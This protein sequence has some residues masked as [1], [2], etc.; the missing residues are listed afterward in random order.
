MINNSITSINIKLLLLLCMKCNNSNKLIIDAYTIG[1]YSKALN[2][3]YIR[4]SLDILIW[5]GLL[6]NIKVDTYMINPNYYSRCS[7]TDLIM[8]KKEWNDLSLQHHVRPN[9]LY[10]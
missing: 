3:K 4:G 1:R 6:N 10:S 5:V 8:L 2:Y 7:N 9:H